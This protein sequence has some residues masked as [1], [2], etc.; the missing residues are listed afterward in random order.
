MEI[1]ANGSMLL[2]YWEGIFAIF[3][4]ERLIASILLNLNMVGFEQ[5]KLFIF[6]LDIDGKVCEAMRDQISR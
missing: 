5:V 2:F 1:L 4:T 6:G 3:C